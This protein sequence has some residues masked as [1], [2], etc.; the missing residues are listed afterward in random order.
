MSDPTNENEA[1]KSGPPVSAGEKKTIFETVWADVIGGVAAVV[2]GVGG[3]WRSIDEKFYQNIKVAP[4]VNALIDEGKRETERIYAEV[5]EMRAE[6][7]VKKAI[8]NQK[9]TQHNLMFESRLEEHLAK[10]FGIKSLSDKIHSLRPHQ[11][12]E[13]FI[14]VAAIM[15]VTLGGAA[16]LIGNRRTEL[17]QQELERRLAEKELREQPRR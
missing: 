15:A 2:A 16:A 13:V 11:R 14:N 9:L 7:S 6:G 17:K 8:L 12:N 5:R 1:A 10:S 4:K 3:A